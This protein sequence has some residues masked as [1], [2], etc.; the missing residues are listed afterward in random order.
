MRTTAL[1]ITIIFVLGCKSQ[2]D[3]QSQSIQDDFGSNVSEIVT[4]EFVE[5]SLETT[6]RPRS[7]EQ[8]TSMF[9]ETYQSDPK[10]AFANFLTGTIYL[11]SRVVKFRMGS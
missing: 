2:A 1:L 4:V 6:E 9:I 11:I 8:L 5:S 10:T 3:T 7:S